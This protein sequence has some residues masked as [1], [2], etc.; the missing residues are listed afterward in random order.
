[1]SKLCK[2]FILYGV[3]IVVI[4]MLI[5][6]EQILKIALPGVFNQ[7][8]PY[9]ALI[10]NALNPF[11]FYIYVWDEQLKNNFL[12]LYHCIFP[13]R[14]IIY[15]EMLISVSEVDSN[16]LYDETKIISLILYN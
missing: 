12:V 14:W 11:I 1:M 13:K 15:N 4:S 9:V 2:L 16:K 5:L 10:I 6:L 8:S 3:G 7:I